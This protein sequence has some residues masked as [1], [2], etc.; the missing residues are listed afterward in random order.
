[1][2]YWV[3]ALRQQVA[4]MIAG[5]YLPG[6]PAFSRAPD[7]MAELSSELDDLAVLIVE[8]EETRKALAMEVHHRVKNNLQIVTSLLNMQASRIENPAAREALGQTRARIGAL[9][10]IH[11]ILYEKADDGSQA[12]LE[13][14]RLISELCAQFRQWNSDRTEIVFS[15]DSAPCSVPLDSAMPLALFAVEA[16]TNAYAYAFPNAL[17]GSVRLQF[18]CSADGE[19]SLA[20]VD[21]GIGFDTA[22][23]VNSMGRELMNGFAEQLGGRLLIESNPKSGTE[24]RLDYRIVQQP[25]PA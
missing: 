13:I 6:T 20:I 8:R 9:A 23:N 10:L 5:D 3:T 17:S 15:C 22:H 1:V 16:V 7:G 12:T 25:D 4:Q 2:E 19:A 24:V 14:S 18:R 21:D 11:R